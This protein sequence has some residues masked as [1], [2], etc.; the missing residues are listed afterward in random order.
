MIKSQYKAKK[1]LIA[2]KNLKDCT[3]L[4]RLKNRKFLPLKKTIFH[5]KKGLGIMRQMRY[6]YMCKRSTKV[7]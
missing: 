6:F 4:K 5:S 3:E 2:K 7:V 1:M